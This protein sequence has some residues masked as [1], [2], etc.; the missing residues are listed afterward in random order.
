MSKTVM[1]E[2]PDSIYAAVHRAATF[3]G[4]TPD[5]WIIGQ[6]VRELKHDEPAAGNGRKGSSPGPDPDDPLRSLFGS[7][8]AG[9]PTGSDNDRI[10]ADLAREYGDTH[11]TES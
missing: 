11:D 4:T 10:D 2:L 7:V 5:A 6:V 8:R 3:A 9:D 1:L